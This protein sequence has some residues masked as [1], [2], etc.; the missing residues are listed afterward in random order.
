MT[1]LFRRIREKLIASG[2]ITK[3]Q[4][5]AVGEILLVVIGILIALQINNWNEDQQAKNRMLTNILSIQED[6]QQ[7]TQLLGYVVQSLHSQIES[8]DSIIP[9]MESRDGTVQDSLKFILDFNRLT[10]TPIISRRSN[11]WDFLNASGDISEF[12]DSELLSMLQDY[13]SDLEQTA[14]N[15]T[16]TAIPPR[17][18][19]RKLKYELFTDTEHRKFFPTSTPKAPGSAV[20]DSI[21]DDPRVLP[22]CR[23]IGGTARYFENEFISLQKK[24][25]DLSDYINNTYL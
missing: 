21:L 8:S 3:Y 7:K 5:Y 19:L 1:P 24:S 23:Y 25:M 22:L 2:S 10:N 17:L 9:Y 11:T 13:Y 6:I 16:N 14:I 20:Y 12:P 18:D 4:L 15:F